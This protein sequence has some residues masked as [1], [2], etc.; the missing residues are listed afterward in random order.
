MTVQIFETEIWLAE[1][2]GIEEALDIVPPEAGQANLTRS[3]D[4]ELTAQESHVN[5]SR[6]E[7]LRYSESASSLAVSR[8]PFNSRLKPATT[9]GGV[10]IPQSR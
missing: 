3:H 7:T 6:R 2:T 5:L 8:H 1:V 10:S 4:F 9:A